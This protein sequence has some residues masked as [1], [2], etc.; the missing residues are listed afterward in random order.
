MGKNPPSP[1]REE[2][3]ASCEVAVENRPEPIEFSLHSVLQRTRTSNIRKCNNLFSMLKWV[4][5]PLFPIR[6]GR[7]AICEVAVEN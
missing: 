3:S 1:I 5:N 4:K 2:R 7:V 6:K